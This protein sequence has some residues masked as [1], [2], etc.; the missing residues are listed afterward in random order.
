M[1]SETRFALILWIIL[2]IV[3]TAGGLERGSLS[4]CGFFIIIGIELLAI[5]ALLPRKRS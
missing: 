3:G 4:I 2:L 1:R 5:V